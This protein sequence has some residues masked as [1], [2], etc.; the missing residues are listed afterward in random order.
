M[1]VAPSLA[2]ALDSIPVGAC[3]KE[4]VSFGSVIPLVELD[5]GIVEGVEGLVEYS[6]E[7][8]LDLGVAKDSGSA[9]PVWRC[10]ILHILWRNWLRL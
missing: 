4:V 3:G 8:S 5:I 1:G 9:R 6:L 10:L 7:D 2:C